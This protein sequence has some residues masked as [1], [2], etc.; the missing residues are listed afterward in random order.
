MA[1]IAT[2]T[3][4]VAL[5]WNSRTCWELCSMLVDRVFFE[6]GFDTSLVLMLL[7]DTLDH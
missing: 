6:A 5:D 3:T 4:F 2:S 7:E 1:T